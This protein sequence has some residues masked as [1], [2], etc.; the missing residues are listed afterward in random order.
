[1]DKLR[2]AALRESLKHKPDEELR[3]I[4]AE[5]N[6][7]EWT[8]EAFAVMR[9][10]LQE[11][12]VAPPEASSGAVER[13][14]SGAVARRASRDTCP[15]CGSNYV[16][17]VRSSQVISMSG[18]RACESCG[19]VW[20]PP[21]PKWAAWIG[22]VTGGP[23]AIFIFC[24]AILNISEI[25]FLGLLVS[26]AGVL[27]IGGCAFGCLLV[28]LG[29]AGRFKLIED[30]GRSVREKPL[31]ESAGTICKGCGNALAEGAMW[32]ATCNAPPKR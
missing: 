7:S 4:L 6:T 25:G 32:C 16:Y 19:S 8:P 23:L 29:N 26:Q 28:L 13:A 22:L 3:Q 5:S 10:I 15:V 11:R 17:V 27:M 2:L 14:S 30:R 24:F 9:T 20:A 31:G 1:M 12:A 21:V 18:D